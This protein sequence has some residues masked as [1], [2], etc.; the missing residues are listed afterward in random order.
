MNFPCEVYILWNI[1]DFITVLNLIHMFS[2]RLIPGTF[3]L[4]TNIYLLVNLT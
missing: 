3:T 1:D 4:R 2:C